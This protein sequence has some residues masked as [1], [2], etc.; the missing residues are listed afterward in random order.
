MMQISSPR[1]MWGGIGLLVVLFGSLFWTVLQAI[2][3][4]QRP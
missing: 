2:F 4:L 3:E 1:N